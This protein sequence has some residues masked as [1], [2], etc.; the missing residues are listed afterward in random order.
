[1]TEMYGSVELPMLERGRDL[2]LNI[3]KRAT[4]AG[5]IHGLHAAADAEQGD[6]GLLCQVDH[7]QFK[8][9]ATFAH[10]SE[11][12]A[13]ALTIQHWW[14]VRSAS[15]EEESVNLLEE[16]S[17]RGPVCMEWKDQRNAA[18]FFNGA[19][20]AGTQKIGG[21]APAPFLPITGIKVWCDPDDRFHRLAVRFRGRG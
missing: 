12:I 13:L 17:S 16:A 20:V 6:I 15:G 14:K 10:G 3:L 1:M 11:G 2:G 8:I 19:N 7:V 9:C 21:L 5:D 4:A 18:E